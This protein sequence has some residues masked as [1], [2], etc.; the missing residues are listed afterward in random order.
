VTVTIENGRLLITEGSRV[1][2]DTNEK[3][4]HHIGSKIDQTINRPRFTTPADSI[5]WRRHEAEMAT[6]PAGTQCIQG[7]VR[8][9]YGNDG[10]SI[11]PAGW[12]VAGGSILLEHKVFQSLAGSYDRYVSA[13]MAISVYMASG[14]LRF[15][16]DFQYRDARSSVSAGAFRSY[17]MRSV[18][19]PGAFN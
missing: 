8:V 4:L 1:V 14:K 18:V 15:S 5:N 19:F 6:L 12:Y 17:S 7:L 10:G 3:M 13:V 11:L 9:S 2:L 16:E